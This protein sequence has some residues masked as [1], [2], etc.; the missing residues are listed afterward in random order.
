MRLTLGF[1]NCVDRLS[2]LVASVTTMDE[3]AL[4]M[5]M[6]FSEPGC[7]SHYCKCLG[8][9]PCSTDSISRIIKVAVRTTPWLLVACHHSWPWAFLM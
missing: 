9:A 5:V 2:I 6:V 3:E 1:S 7:L 8:G 4:V